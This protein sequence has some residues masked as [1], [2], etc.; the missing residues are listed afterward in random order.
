MCT[1]E[2]HLVTFDVDFISDNRLNKENGCWNEHDW[3]DLVG[4]GCSWYEQGE[5]CKYYG[6][7]FSYDSLMVSDTCSTYG[8]GLLE[9][10]ERVDWASTLPGSSNS[11]SNLVDKFGACCEWY[12][13]GVRC[14]KFGDT[15]GLAGKTALESLLHLRWRE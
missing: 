4:D 2:A 1:V 12:T 7:G 9:A 11:P 14:D 15:I 10:P 3:Y 5:N 8:G 6:R 13:E